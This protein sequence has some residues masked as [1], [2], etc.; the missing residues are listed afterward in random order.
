MTVPIGSVFIPCSIA[1]KV[2]AE[3]DAN[4]ISFEEK[5]IVGFEDGYAA[6]IVCKT[7]K[8]MQRVYDIMRSIEDMDEELSA[9]A[10]YC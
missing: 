1:D 6:H 2:K 8:D 3:I 10:Q 4:H 5:G 7:C 9:H